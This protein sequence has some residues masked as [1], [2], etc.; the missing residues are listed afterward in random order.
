MPHGDL[1]YG[2]ILAATPVATDAYA[3]VEVALPN[4]VGSGKNVL[5]PVITQVDLTWS[6]LA[7]SGVSADCYL[8][9]ALCNGGAGAWASMPGGGLYDPDCIAYYN[10]V[11]ALTTSG[12]VAIPN[13]VSIPL[14]GAGIIVTAPALT[15]MQHNSGTGAA[16][17]VYSRIW[18]DYVAMDEM[19]Y[20]RTVHAM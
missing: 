14:P 13:S 1:F 17:V 18:Y 3:E 4:S 6:P 12:Q 16:L 5:V 15:L 8:Q 19:E 9:V 20:L 11:L 7:L 10:L 2:R